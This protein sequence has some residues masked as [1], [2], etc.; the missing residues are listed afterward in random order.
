MS[1]E[2]PV[3]SLRNLEQRRKIE[4]LLNELYAQLGVPPPPLQPSKTPPSPLRADPN[5]PV[6]VVPARPPAKTRQT[7]KHTVTPAWPIKA[8]LTFVLVIAALMGTSIGFT[9]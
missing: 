5:R 3:F 8:L 1:D 9:R 4:A 6:W 7:G 2:R